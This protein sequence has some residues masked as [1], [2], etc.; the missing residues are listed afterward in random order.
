MRTEVTKMVTDG[1][2][3]KLLAYCIWLIVTMLTRHEKEQIVVDL[4]NQGKTIRDIAKEVRIS[5]RDI[6]AILKKASGETEEKQDIKGS[7]SL[8]NKAY[9]LFSKGKTPIQVAITLNLSET[10]T[11]KFYQE[12]WN[13]KQM[14]ELRMVY[15]EIGADIV[16]FLALYRLS[17]DAHMN[18]RQ[19]INLL[20]IAN[21]DLQSVEQRYQKLQRNVNDLEDRELDASITLEDLQSQIQNAKQRL[22][23][24]RLSCQKEVGKGLQLHRQNM[25]L[26][27]LLRQFKNNN[28]EYLKI[29]YVAK[30]TV[31]ST[32]SD[33]RQLL[34]F[35]LLS[36]IESLCAD[37]IKFNFLIHSMP[38]PLTMPKSTII[39]YAG[40]SG[41]YHIKS[42]SSDYNQNNYTET[43]IEVIVN[44]TASLYEKMV[45]DFTNQTITNAAAVSS[46]NVLSSMTYLDEQTDHTQASLA[47]RHITQTSVYDQ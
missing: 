34:K 37:P 10:E 20:Q 2:S 14:Y 17:K 38:P 35:A 27:T 32:L 4:Y 12:Y 33:S 26:D 1:N 24:Y 5:F 39:D 41:N 42:S 36:I 23:S 45:K 18:P 3:F 15:E 22:N 16:H 31:R 40:T 29:R 30:Q 46:S 47:Y 19:T 9:R 8:S 7:L 28:E 25:T 13:L 6:G 43:L 44:K 11:T 21:N